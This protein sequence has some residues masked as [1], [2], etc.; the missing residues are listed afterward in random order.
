MGE[1]SARF[2]PGQ[3]FGAHPHQSME[4]LSFVASGALEHKD[5][6]GNSGVVHTGEF[7]YMGARSGVVH[8][9][10]NPSS[11]EPVHFLQIWILPREKGGAPAYR[12]LEHAD[13]A[14]VRRL[15]PPGLAGRTR[16]RR[17]RGRPR[18]TAS[19]GGDVLSPLP[20]CLSR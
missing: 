12:D 13:P 3:G 11:S 1:R 19:S 17:H 15:G 16:R 5:C 14:P 6:L 4:I 18:R 10:F 7:Q 9:E 20:A 2:L 8:S